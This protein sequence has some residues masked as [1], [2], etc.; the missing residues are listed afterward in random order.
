MKDTFEATEWVKRGTM[1]IRRAALDAHDPESWPSLWQAYF[2]EPMPQYK[3]EEVG[4]TPP[5]RYCA[6]CGHEQ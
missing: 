1:I 4:C 6:N 5:G 2:K 3:C